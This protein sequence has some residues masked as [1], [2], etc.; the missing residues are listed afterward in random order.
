MPDPKKTLLDCIQD[1]YVAAVREDVQAAQRGDTS[2]RAYTC[3][4]SDALRGVL[5]DAGL[6][7]DEMEALRQRGIDA[8]RRTIP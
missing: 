5:M 6:S 4:A 2:Q 1:R 7:T 3:G 8:A